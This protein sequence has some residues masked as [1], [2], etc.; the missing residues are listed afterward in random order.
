MVNEQGSADRGQ[1][2]VGGVEERVCGRGVLRAYSF[3]YYIFA[4]K[5]IIII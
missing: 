3:I 4:Y 5:D 2:L 1:C